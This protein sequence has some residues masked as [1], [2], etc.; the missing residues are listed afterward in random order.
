MTPCPPTPRTR[1][2]GRPLHRS[3]PTKLRSTTIAPLGNGWNV[4]RPSQSSHPE[5]SHHLEGRASLSDAPQILLARVSFFR[6]PEIDSIAADRGRRERFIAE[7]VLRDHF[8][9]L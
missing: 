9:L 5:R 8:E 1:G 6:S 3:H 2:L 7:L 4:C